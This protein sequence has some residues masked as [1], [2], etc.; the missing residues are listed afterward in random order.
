MPSYHPRAPKSSRFRPS[1][2]FSALV[3][4]GL[5]CAGVLSASGGGFRIV[6]AKSFAKAAPIGPAPLAAA[7]A[8]GAVPPLEGPVMAI[9]ITVTDQNSGEFDFDA[10]AHTGVDGAPLIPGANLP[11]A[12]GLLDSGA[13]THLVSYPDSLQLGLE[14]DWVTAN[15][16]SAE[17]AGGA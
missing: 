6:S 9:A 15:T 16:F 5:F 12:V 10:T 2:L 7:A 14:G 4:L 11:V 1:I 3:V 13:S 17:G 8:T